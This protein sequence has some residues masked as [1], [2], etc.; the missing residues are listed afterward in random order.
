MRPTARVL[1]V[2]M[3]ECLAAATETKD[4]D[5]V[6]V[7]AVGSAFDDRVEAG[8]IAPGTDQIRFYKSWMGTSSSSRLRRSRHRSKRRF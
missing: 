2:Q 6:L 4:L 7:A 5:V 8:D 3:R 1:E